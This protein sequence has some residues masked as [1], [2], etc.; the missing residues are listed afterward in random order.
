MN[1]RINILL[2]GCG[3]PGA[4]GI[5]Q[6]LKKDPR[7]HVFGVDMDPFA[8]GRHLVE[9]F[10]TIPDSSDPNFA[11][12]I[13]SFCEQRQIDAVIPIVTTEL[14]PLAK[15]FNNRKILKPALL[16]HHPDLLITL[17]DKGAVYQQFKELNFIPK[18]QLI[19]TSEELVKSLTSF[20]PLVVKP[21]ISNGSRGVRVLHQDMDRLNAWLT[22]K[23]GNLDMSKSEFISIVNQREIPPLVV[24]EYLPGTE[25]TVDVLYHQA[26][27]YSSAI[28]TREKMRS[29]I[30]TQG[31]FVL[32]Q[33]ITEALKSIGNRLHLHGFFGFQFKEDANGH[34]KL[35][36]VNPRL[37]GTTVAA[38][39]AGVN[40]PLLLLQQHLNELPEIAPQVKIGVSFS[41]VFKEIY[42]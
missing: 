39:G 4:A 25:Y 42:H 15:A 6:C 14:I 30:S 17:N 24:S 32:N 22:Q 16:S 33:P 7:I 9:S 31:R 20:E 41:R 3:A 29:G 11:E 19:N 10:Q 38:L 13:L 27:I 2:T 12:A 35:L 23:P 26:E 1:K 18:F 40:F 5:I 28:R 21:R 34:P 8:S 36:E 37:Q